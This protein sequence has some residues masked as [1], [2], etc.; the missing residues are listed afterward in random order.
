VE[1]INCLITV[2]VEASGSSGL[3]GLAGG[4]TDES[5]L[6]AGDLGGE[7]FSL[8]GIVLNLELNLLVLV[9]RSEALGVDVGLVDKDVLATVLR[10]DE[11][12]SLDSVEKFNTAGG[13]EPSKG[14]GLEGSGNNSG[15]SEHFI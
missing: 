13:L 15:N 8:S 2:I 14:G 3:S 9:K 10:G 1:C 11:T 6:G 12:E 7:V 5:S 4:A